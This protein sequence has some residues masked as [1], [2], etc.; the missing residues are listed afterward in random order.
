ML[1]D[2]QAGSGAFRLVPLDDEVV[3]LPA[4]VGA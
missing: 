1:R 2:G 3:E 4:I